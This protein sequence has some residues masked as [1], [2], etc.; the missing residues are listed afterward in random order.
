MKLWQSDLF[1]G[2]AFGEVDEE[3]RQTHKLSRRAALFAFEFLKDR[4]GTKAA[5]RSGFSE[6]TAAQAASR[7]LRNVKVKAAID[8]LTE[9][10]YA[11]CQVTAERIRFEALAVGFSTAKDLIGTDGAPLRLVDLPD[12]VARA[13]QSFELDVDGRLKLSTVRF[14]PK[15]EMVKLL[16]QE[17]RMWTPDDAGMQPGRFILVTG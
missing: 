4:N 12:S 6:K 13:I 9:K 1:Q 5:T 2:V 10:V 7:L 8:S 16:G 14:W 15:A 17:K 11:Q 3:I